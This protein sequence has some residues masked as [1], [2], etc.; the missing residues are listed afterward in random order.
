MK[1]IIVTKNKIKTVQEL[2]EF[3]DILSKEK[4]FIYRGCTN[5]ECAIKK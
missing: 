2:F 4:R 3:L 5:K 1:K